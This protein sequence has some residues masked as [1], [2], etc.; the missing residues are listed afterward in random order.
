MVNTITPL[1]DS[2]W[3]VDGAVAIEAAFAA[4]MLSSRPRYWKGSGSQ[5]RILYSGTLHAS[6]GVE[7]RCACLRLSI[8]GR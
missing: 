3:S 6:P 7:K 8:L 1:S 5:A 4:V 2:P